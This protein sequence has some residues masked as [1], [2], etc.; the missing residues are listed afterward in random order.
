MYSTN[1]SPT[2]WEQLGFRDKSFGEILS[3][4]LSVFFVEATVSVKSTL[5]P[6]RRRKSED[7]QGRSHLPVLLPPSGSKDGI[8]TTLKI[9]GA[10]GMNSMKNAWEMSLSQ[11]MVMPNYTVLQA[12]IKYDMAVQLLVAPLFVTLVIMVMARIMTLVCQTVWRKSYIKMRSHMDY[13]VDWAKGNFFTEALVSN[14]KCNTAGFAWNFLDKAERRICRLTGPLCLGK[15]MSKDDIVC[16]FRMNRFLYFD[17]KW[18]FST[19]MMK[20]Q[21]RD[22]EILVNA[23]RRLVTGLTKCR[24]DFKLMVTLPRTVYRAVT[25]S[26]TA[27]KK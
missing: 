10:T 3:M 26:K 17:R 20:H 5:V 1:R 13:I 7:T 23:W 27:K 9:L 6:V 4:M 21:T 11:A 12:M 15:S 19:R 16:V 8:E 14:C 24:Q 25:N 22:E 18:D 2:L